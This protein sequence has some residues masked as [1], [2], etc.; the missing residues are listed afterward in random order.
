MKQNLTRRTICLVLLLAACSAL[1]L[2]GCRAGTKSAAEGQ[3][4]GHGTAAQTDEPTTVARPTE[5]ATEEALP[6][7]PE[8]PT[9]PSTEP[10]PFTEPAL[11]A[12]PFQAQY[13]RTDHYMEGAEYPQ[14]RLVRSPEEL[15]AFY[16]EF[17]GGDSLMRAS[18][19]A[20]TIPSAFQVYDEAF[21][22]DHSLIVVR[23][24]EGSGS[25]RHEVTAVVLDSGTYLVHINR[26]LPA[27]GYAGTC[28]MAQWHILIEIP[29]AD[30]SLPPDAVNLQITS[31]E[32]GK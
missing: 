15:I 10:I 17:L 22:L 8:I 5:A 25:N 20:S 9:E 7:E 24:E 23:V 21:F 1:L 19:P 31:S 6:T 18:A 3:Q 32:T 29:K 11:E 13:V 12:V 27:P 16:N 30:D 28:D 26:I 2:C 4:T 14:S